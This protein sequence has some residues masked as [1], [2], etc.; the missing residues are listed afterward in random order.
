MKIRDLQPW[1]LYPARLSFKTEGETRNFP[2]KKLK[3]FVNA[4]PVNNKC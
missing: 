1:L 3:E 2:D 4:K